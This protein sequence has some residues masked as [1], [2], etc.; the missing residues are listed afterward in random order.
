MASLNRAA[1][2][3]AS[4]SAIALS[5]RTFSDSI[6]VWRWRSFGFVSTLEKD[7]SAFLI[8]LYPHD[9]L[10]FQFWP[11]VSG[12]AQRLL[13]RL[14]ELVLPLAPV[15]TRMW[16]RTLT[17]QSPERLPWRWRAHNQ[18]AHRCGVGKDQARAAA[19]TLPPPPQRALDL[20]FHASSLHGTFLCSL[21]R[22]PLPGAAHLPGWHQGLWPLM[23][24]APHQRGPDPPIA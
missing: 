18:D 13:R 19:Q 2:A 17:A 10:N 8:Q 4:L 21:L 11:I 9:F 14:R 24:P 16:R 12:P 20:V 7:A 22:S 5:N 3:F 6:R 15:L 1:F 23:I